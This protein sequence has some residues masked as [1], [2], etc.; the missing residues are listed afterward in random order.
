MNMQQ[1]EKYW[2]NNGPK[3]SA[4]E[5]AIHYIYRMNFIVRDA[6]IYP[7]AG[8]ELSKEDKSAVEYLI[9]DCGYLWGGGT[10][11]WSKKFEID[12]SKAKRGRFAKKP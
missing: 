8:F 10:D 11:D 1:L 4:W 3:N 2:L 5:N 9:F 7:P 12:W 6:V